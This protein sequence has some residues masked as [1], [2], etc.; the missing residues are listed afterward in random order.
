MID[1]L[2]IKANSEK[3]YNSIRYFYHNLSQNKKHDFVLNLA[4]QNIYL[5]AQ[6]VMTSQKDEIIEKKLISI[7][8]SFARDFF[9]SEKSAN[10]FLALVEF[11]QFLI[12]SDLLRVVQNP[13]KTHLLVFK[14]I[15]ESNISQEIFIQFLEV[16]LSI[17]KIPLV[18]YCVMIYNGKI[19]I[20]ED[21]KYVFK[22]LFELLFENGNYGIS[23]LILEKYDLFNDLKVIFNMQPLDL[24]IKLIN[25]KK[26]RIP[27]IQLA[28]EIYNRF[29]LI[30]KL[31]SEIFLE[32]LFEL[33]SEKSLTLAFSI[34]KR[35]KI[36]DKRLNEQI[37]NLLNSNRKNSRSISRVKRRI[38]QLINIGFLEYIMQ[39]DALRDQFLR[40][41]ESINFKFE[42]KKDIFQVKET[43]FS[44]NEYSIYGDYVEIP[45]DKPIENII[46]EYFKMDNKPSLEILVNMLIFHFKSSY[47]EISHLLRAYEFT[48]VIKASFDY[49]YYVESK[50]VISR[51][52]LFLHKVQ[53]FEENESDSVFLVGDTLKFRIIGINQK[54]YR[55]NISCLDKFA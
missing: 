26:K 27:A 5:A 23:K 22:N 54:N 18:S 52:L 33:N 8:E 21:N 20:S 36:N 53:A 32:R 19:E 4:D 9:D 10:G 49:G 13:T 45:I 11:E 55:F 38:N 44:K 16:L 3:Y 41:E 48:G 46:N 28:Y 40:F 47:L 25:S 51:N 6:C 14:K 30:K 34:A 50:D 43:L 2:Y 7:A 12:I 37:S 42:K 29:N 17:K 35:Q 39:N 1:N 24:V 31:K 15:F